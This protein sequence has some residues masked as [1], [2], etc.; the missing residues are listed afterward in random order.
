MSNLYLQ[1]GD[2]TL[3][4]DYARRAVRQSPEDA[5]AL[6]QLDKSYRAFGFFESALVENEKSIATDVATLFPLYWHTWY[7]VQLGR[8]N[9][10]KESIVK[11][12]AF[13]SEG[14][15]TS[16]TEALLE[17]HKGNYKRA[18][19]LYEMTKRPSLTYEAHSE[20][21]AALA[22]A[23]SGNVAFGR[24]VLQKYVAD[25][26]RLADGII[27]LAGASGQAETM[28]K[29]TRESQSFASYGWLVRNAKFFRNIADRKPF[30]DLV[31]DL[32]KKWET[33]L[34][35]I[36]PTLPVRP[37][38]LP[39]P[40]ELLAGLRKPPRV[41]TGIEVLFE[42]ASAGLYRASSMTTRPKSWPS[43]SSVAAG[44]SAAGS[45]D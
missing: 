8:F 23:A 24:S 39:K 22:R 21:G 14:V 32:H 9:E 35:E 11:L 42:S 45:A 10:A 18:M 20:I 2:F 38:E 43:R 29:L 6:H 31:L 4:L 33:D 28:A 30:Q 12:Q 5:D 27:L 1:G 17:L 3:A 7:L 25:G 44:R 41:K 36:G 26:P 37:P 19:E 15:G 13:D 40:E 16:A 34:A